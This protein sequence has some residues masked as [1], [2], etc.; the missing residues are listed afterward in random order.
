MI[1]PR[2]LAGPILEMQSDWI[3]D[4]GPFRKCN[5]IGLKIWAQVGFWAQMHMIGPHIKLGPKT[6]FDWMSARVGPNTV[7]RFCSFLLDF[8]SW[9]ENTQNGDRLTT[10]I[11]RLYQY[12]LE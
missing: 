12:V 8:A 9:G 11:A 1:G 6:A 3:K 7:F 10:R 5:L 4:L 2:F